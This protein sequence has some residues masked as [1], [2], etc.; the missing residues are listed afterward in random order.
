MEAGRRG[1]AKTKAVAESV[2]N[3]QKGGKSD[4][5]LVARHG[6]H[7]QLRRRILLSSS[8]IIV[9]RHSRIE[10]AFCPGS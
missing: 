3:V 10:G 7:A 2:L 4:G 5:R 1:I 6:R 9:I 8:G